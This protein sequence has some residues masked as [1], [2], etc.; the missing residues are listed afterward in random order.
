MPGSA[1][2]KSSRTTPTRSPSTPP[3]T[4]VCVP[5]IA[6]SRSAQSSAVRAIGPTVSKVGDTGKSPSFETRPGVGRRPV[7]PQ[8]ADG[9]RIDP[10]VS[11][12]SVPAARSAAAAAAEPPL[13]PPQT[14]SVAQGFRAGP[15]C[16]L[17]V[18]A[19]NANS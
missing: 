7:T 15:K 11:V 5:A 8:N 17:V 16:G 12:P 1:S 14:R 4:S 13:E 3:V 9:M 10:P 18:S 19:P 2:S 6:S